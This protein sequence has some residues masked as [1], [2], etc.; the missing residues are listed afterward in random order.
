V[1]SIHNVESLTTLWAYKMP[2]IR[3]FSALCSVR[4]AAVPNRKRQNVLPEMTFSCRLG[5]ITSLHGLKGALNYLAVA[6]LS[7]F[8]IRH[9]KNKHITSRKLWSRAEFVVYVF[10]WIRLDSNSLAVIF[11]TQL[12]GKSFNLFKKS[13]FLANF[14]FEK[15]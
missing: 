7:R 2:L 1:C 5:R 8:S 12:S 14:S 4:D 15:F 3:S 6:I 10:N 11:L 13:I 9:V